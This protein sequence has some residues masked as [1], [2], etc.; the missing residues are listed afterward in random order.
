M[1]IG[2]DGATLDLIRPWAQ[3]GY[4][5]TLAS[6][7]ETGGYSRL[8]SVLPV[9][10]SAAWATFMT[11]T[12]PGKHGVFDFVYREARSY[13]LRPVNRQ[14]IGMPSLWRLLSEQ[15]RRVGVLN[16]PITYPPEPVNGFLV[17]GLGT[18]DFKCFTYPPELSNRLLEN[19]Y[20]VN[21]RVYYPWSNEEAFLRDTY[22]ITERL[23][24]TA[25]SLLAETPWDFFMVVYR[26]TDDVAHGFWHHMDPSHPDHDPVQSA[27]YRNVILEFY[28]QLDKYLGDLVAAAG[29][30]T[31][32]FVVS[33]H[34]FGPLYKEVFLNEWLHQRGYLIPRSSSYR[35]FLSRIGLT[36]NNVSRFLRWAHLGRMERMIKDLLG[37]HIA[38]LPQTK[39]ADFS[40]G[41]DWSH[42]RA[43]SFGYQ[44]QIYINLAGREP[45]GIVAP[46]SEYE[47]L[48]DELC[49]AL[50]ELSDPVDGHPVIDRIYKKEDLYWGSNLFQAPD[51]VIVMRDLAYITRL[52][53]ELGG[54]PGEVFG[55]SR[56]HESGGHRLDGVLIAAGPG[57]I[58]S[59]E[60]RPAAWLGD[61]APTILHLLGCAVPKSMDGRVLREWLIPALA[62]RPVQPFKS[63]LPG[64]ALES[65]GLTAS[66]E[67]EIL[68]R[69]GDLGYLG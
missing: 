21:R 48:R 31:T 65:E 67:E 41:I 42:T 62:D 2:L 22:E 53:Y 26:D 58:R 5:P 45:Q 11:G 28:R 20:R 37:D 8:H 50:G 34:G 35:Q 18:P 63:A 51:L 19:G 1:V 25:L 7:M 69:L 14:H 47:A 27:P 30:D 32:V 12:N 55:S 56:I 4:L 49:R 6:L 24:A 54:Q 59:T 23:T 46:G 15:G 40:E 13:R 60:E 52:G 16:V 44:G 38:L 3:A 61:V 66:E 33:D 36:R 43:Y 10:S 29:P 64:S 57:I 9:V 17:S 39:W 68:E